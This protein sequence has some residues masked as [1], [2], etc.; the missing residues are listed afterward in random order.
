MHGATSHL[1]II[2]RYWSPLSMHPDVSL[3][4]HSKTVLLLLYL[5]GVVSSYLSTWDALSCSTPTGSDT[6]GCF[7][8]Q[9]ICTI[10]LNLVAL[11]QHMLRFRF[12]M[13][14]CCEAACKHESMADRTVS[15]FM[16]HT[17]YFQ[18]TRMLDGYGACKHGTGLSFGLTCMGQHCLLR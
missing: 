11:R 9:S 16:V 12:G 13:L 2:E 4:A 18:H 14:D 3:G 15:C 7:R 5:L 6:S 1:E 10:A 8:G 17:M